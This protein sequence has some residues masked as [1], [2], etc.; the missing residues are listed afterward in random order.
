MLAKV[1]CIGNCTVGK[2]SIIERIR[3][4]TFES[5]V[6]ATAGLRPDWIRAETSDHTPIGIEIWD[7]AGAESYRSLIPHC[8]KNASAVA[9]IYSMTDRDSFHDLSAWAAECR[10]HVADDTAF[11]IVANKADLIEES[12]VKRSEAEQ[13]AH[14]INANFLETSAKT[15]DGIELLLQSIAD[16]AMTH[17]MQSTP[18]LQLRVGAESPEERCCSGH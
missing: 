14:E 7:T 12:Q 17:P 11:V 9:L 1:C 15:G 3:T 13:Y 18:K 16:S 2:T 10:K 8:L 4:G 6:R 5:Q